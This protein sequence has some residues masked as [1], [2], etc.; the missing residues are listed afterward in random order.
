M[1]RSTVLDAGQCPCGG[2]FASR[3]IT[4]PLN[5]LGPG[6]AL[7]DVPESRCGD[8]GTRVYQ[9]ALLRRIESIMRG[10]TR[11]SIAGATT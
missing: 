3:L 7:E 1:P 4:V 11:G 9:A 5:A 10:D 2:T 6:G 8:C